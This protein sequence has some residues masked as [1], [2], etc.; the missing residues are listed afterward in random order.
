MGSDK[1]TDK[2]PARPNIIKILT[3]CKKVF[4]LNKKINLFNNLNSCIVF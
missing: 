2:E 1:K 4:A 3:R